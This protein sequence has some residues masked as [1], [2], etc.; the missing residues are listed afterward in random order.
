MAQLGTLTAGVAHELNN[1]AA[2]VKRGA[3]QMRAALLPLSKTQAALSRH[4]FSAAQQIIIDELVSMAQT[5]APEDCTLDIL[6]RSN[7]EEEL[8][9]WLEEKEIEDPWDLA[10]S[11]TDL[12]F[13]I[14]RLVELSE[15]FSSDALGDILHSTVAIYQTYSLL[16]EIGQGAGRISE[17]VKALK[18]YAYLDQA[19]V[20]SVDIHEG[21]NNTLVILRHKLKQGIEVKRNYDANLPNIQAYGSEL[22][23]VWTNIIDNAIDAL[24]GEGII[25]IETRHDENHVVVELQDNGPGIPDE[26]RSRIFNAFFTT[27]PPGKGTGL[28]LN[29]S[30]NIVV[31]KHNGDIR[32]FSEPGFTC[33]QI[34]LPLNFEDA[35]PTAEVEPALYERGR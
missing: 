5:R 12:D 7:R 1:P 20:Q 34:W 10:S 26:I 35:G 13:S 23:Q 19:P 4:E 25:T 27:K 8:E 29:I 11:L 9:D 16:R 2:A 6:G 18:S 14:E 24:D 17:I 22:N 21:I 33:F 3:D 30:Y 28:G 32:V 15:K 31:Y